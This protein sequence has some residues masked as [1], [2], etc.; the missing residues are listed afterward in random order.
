MSAEEIVFEKEKNE[1]GD[2]KGS[3]NIC[4]MKMIL[5]EKEITVSLMLL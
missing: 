3:D 1:D 5:L 2:I 4:F